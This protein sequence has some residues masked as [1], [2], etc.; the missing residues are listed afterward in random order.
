MTEVPAPFL[1]HP[2]RVAERLDALPTLAAQLNPQR[3]GVESAAFA[4]WRKSKRQI[5]KVLANIE[6]THGFDDLLERVDHWLARSFGGKSLR[7]RDRASWRAALAELEIADHFEARGF[8]TRG[9]DEE[10]GPEPTA[11]MRVERDGVVATVEVYSPVEWEGIDYFT[12]DAWDT[13]RQLDLPYG[14]FFRF[15]VAQRQPFL[16]GRYGPLHPEELTRGL[17]TLEKRRRLLQPLFDAV[18]AELERGA[19][20]VLVEQ[21]DE[22]LNISLRVALE[23][24]EP[25]TAPFEPR[26]GVQ[27]PPGFG[28]Y[29]PELIF[30][31]VI[32]RALAKAREGQ[33]RT[34][35]GDMA[36]LIVDV[37]RL[38]LDSELGNEVYQRLFREILNDYFPSSSTL[39]VDVL[40]L[41]RSRGWRSEARTHYAVWEEE[42]VSRD[43]CEALLGPLR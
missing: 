17:D 35:R 38:P 19:E 12:Q 40:A 11:D 14:Y 2:E 43:Q 42:R 41:C 27:G 23:G 36:V 21:E 5:F 8:S 32:G 10:R 37:G 6:G 1:F 29:R 18:V 9:L 25:T 4:G 3:E 16:G 13:L 7:A 22:E 24:V 39:P 33:A 34:G 26:P 31:D 15:D 20:P 28:G 30:R